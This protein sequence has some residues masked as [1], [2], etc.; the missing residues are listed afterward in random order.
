M[1]IRVAGE[2]DKYLM[3]DIANELFHMGLPRFRP[4]IKTSRLWVM[5]Y[6]CGWKRWMPHGGSRLF[7]KRDHHANFSFRVNTLGIGP[8]VL[9]N[10]R[11]V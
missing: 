9:M 11:R 10:G 2:S 7:T 1:P 6:R 8:L 4:W 5:W 3:D